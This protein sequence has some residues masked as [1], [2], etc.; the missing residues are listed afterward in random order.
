MS[1]ELKFRVWDKEAK[2]MSIAKI[3][4]VDDMFGFRF[5]HR[6]LDE[7]DVSD[8]EIM[9][10]T[11]E[12]D[13]DKKEIYEGDILF[14]SNEEGLFLQLVEFGLPEKEYSIFLTGFKI[15]KGRKIE[16][17]QTFDWFKDEET[18]KII[19]KYGITTILDEDFNERYVIDGLWVIGNKYENPEL[20]EMIEN[21]KQEE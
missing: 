17:D 12:K 15:T 18:E 14:S 20:V 8:I 13:T 10:Y 7:E 3:E 1:R 11:G 9:Q 5:R 16:S 21:K 19:E 2:V 4:Y 6:D